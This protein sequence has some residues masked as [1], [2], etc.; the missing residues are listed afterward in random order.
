MPT[1]T[2]TDDKTIKV[3]IDGKVIYLKPGGKM[4]FSPKAHIRVSGTFEID[5]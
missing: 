3:E 1:I 2:N 4:A 5:R